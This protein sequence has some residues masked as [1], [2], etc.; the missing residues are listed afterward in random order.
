MISLH[1]KYLAELKSSYKINPWI[2]MQ[3]LRPSQ[4]YFGL[5]PKITD[6]HHIPISKENRYHFPYFTATLCYLTRVY[7][8]IAI[9]MY[10]RRRLIL[11]HPWIHPCY[12]YYL[13]TY[14][15]CHRK[16]FSKVSDILIPQVI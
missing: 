1:Y 3:L 13:L 9:Q 7:D 8:F 10:M 11:S 12:S 6:T 16:Q 5:L 4:V 14:I 15:N 2:H